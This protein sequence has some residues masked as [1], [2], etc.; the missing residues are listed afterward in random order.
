MLESHSLSPP[1]YAASGT[2]HFQ[3][4]A[5]CLVISAIRS[6]QF[7]EALIL[8]VRRINAIHVVEPAFTQS[9]SIYSRNR[10]AVREVECMRNCCTH[11]DTRTHHTHARERR[12]I[13][14]DA[15]TGCEQ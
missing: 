13:R 4:A 11:C 8:Q 6:H 1:L 3:Y 10:I 15:A 2:G 14:V 9:V 5:R 7:L 12:R